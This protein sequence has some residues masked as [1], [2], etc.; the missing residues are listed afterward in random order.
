LCYFLAYFIIYYVGRLVTFESVSM[1]KKKKISLIK[2]T[3]FVTFKL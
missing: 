2:Q 3:L 1:K